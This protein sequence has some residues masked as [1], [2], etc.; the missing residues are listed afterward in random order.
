[1]VK[2]VHVGKVLSGI[3]TYLRLIV[4]Y[5]N[6]KKISHQ[7]I[8]G[9]N[10][11]EI[12]IIDQ[13]NDPVQLYEFDFKR[14]IS[15]VSDIKSIIEIVKIFRKKDFDVIHAHSSKGGLIGRI[16]GLILKKP[17]IYTPHAFS[18]LSSPNKMKHQIFLF[19]E[20]LFKFLTNKFLGCSESEYKRAINDVGYNPKACNF[21]NNS[22]EL[23][24]N[25]DEVTSDY[26]L[27]IGRLCYQKNSDFM[28]E[29]F[30]EFNKTYKLNKK[31]II[32]GVG[33]FSPLKERVEHL[34]NSYK[35]EGL[36]E[37]IPWMS[38]EDT[39]S[40][41]KKAY[42]YI[43]TSRYEGLSI[44]NLEAL[45]YGIPIVASNVDGNRECTRSGETGFLIKMWEAKEFSNCLFK[46]YMDKEMRDEFSINSKNLFNE[47]FNIESRIAELESVYLKYKA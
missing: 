26:I 35:L 2:I 32:I 47:K 14:D 25:N 8:C 21:W 34:I 33:H 5:T 1:M 28:I 15:P 22:I 6:Q 13:K 46:L 40:R 39:I 7:I 20:K 27:A 12:S 43:S 31:L 42:C 45:S 3:D 11:V 19:Y 30:N 17:V 10:E 37:L 9:K 36:V 29:A 41:L 24:E 18:Y 23:R 38:R 4:K 16:M 44:A